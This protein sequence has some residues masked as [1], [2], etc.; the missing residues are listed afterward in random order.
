MELT[1]FLCLM[2]YVTVICQAAHILD[3]ER[4]EKSFQTKTGLTSVD[5]Q[6]DEGPSEENAKEDESGDMVPIPDDVWEHEAG[7]LQH[8]I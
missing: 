8:N 3:S 5:A 1:R 6:V 4:I 7:K 2:A